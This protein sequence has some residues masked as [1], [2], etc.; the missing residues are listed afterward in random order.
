MDGHD[1]ALREAWL[2]VFTPRTWDEF[3][4]A[5]GQILG[6]REGSV[7]LLRMVSPG[8]WLLCYVAKLSRFAAVLEVTSETFVDR[9]P[10]W[11]A[12]PFPNRVRVRP[13]VQVDLAR[14]VDIHSLLDRF[15]WSSTARSPTTWQGHVQNTLRR[16][17]EDDAQV[18]YT[19]LR[20]V[21]TVTPSDG[22]SV[23]SHTS[24]G[25]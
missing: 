7:R 12:E 5:G 19:A 25:D 16:W 18:V 8:D 22:G 2:C 4:A 9:S 6:F 1:Q 23:P 10:I 3:V 15:T 13:L 20:H 24:Q 11:S 17:E 21:S 14:A